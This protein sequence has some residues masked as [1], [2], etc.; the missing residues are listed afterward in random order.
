MTGEHFAPPSFWELLIIN[1]IPFVSES[2]PLLMTV[3][4]SHH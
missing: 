3:D 1:V 2:V 4:I